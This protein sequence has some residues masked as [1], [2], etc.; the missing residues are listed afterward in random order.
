M[1]F[2]RA[3][4]LE[5]YAKWYLERE[6]AKGDSRPIPNRPEQQ[7]QAMWDRHCGK[8]RNWFNEGARWDI[9]DFDVVGDLPN[10][11]FLECP[12]TKQAR[13]VIPDGPNYRLLGRVA[14]SALRYGYLNTLPLEHKHRTYYE[15][16][17]AGTLQLVGADRV[18]VC[19]AE[20]SEIRSNPAARYYLLDGVGRCLPYMMLL[21]ERKVGPAPVEAFLADRG[22]EQR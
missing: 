5:E 7:V 10:L 17:A 14:E 8:M 2:T 1:R 3:S 20:P 12:W 19:S 16:L 4:S 11:V 18:A 21:L 6:T 13:L 22:T 9:A 15:R